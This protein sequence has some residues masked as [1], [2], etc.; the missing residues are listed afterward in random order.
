MLVIVMVIIILGAEGLTTLQVLCLPAK[1]HKMT[2]YKFFMCVYLIIAIITLICGV[3]AAI[4]VGSI[5]L[6]V[7]CKAANDILEAVKNV[8]NKL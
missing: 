5:I 1:E 8:N 2:T 4:T 3:D 6:G 7:V